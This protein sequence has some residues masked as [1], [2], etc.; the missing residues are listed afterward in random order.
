MLKPSGVI[1]CN[2]VCAPCIS[3]PRCARHTAWCGSHYATRD[4]PR[5]TSGHPSSGLRR[6]TAPR[7][8]HA[9]RVSRATRYALRP[10]SPAGVPRHSGHTGHPC[11]GCRPW[12]G[13]GT[14]P[15]GPATPPKRADARDNTAE[16]LVGSRGPRQASHAPSRLVVAPRAELP[17]AVAMRLVARGIR[18]Q[19]GPQEDVTAATPRQRAAKG[20]RPYGETPRVGGRDEGLQGPGGGDELHGRFLRTSGWSHGGLPRFCAGIYGVRATT[21]MRAVTAQVLPCSRD[22]RGGARTARPAW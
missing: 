3:S 17:C 21:R 16:V 4:A 1:G 10:L 13:R 22:N 9:S 11:S 6:S 14:P 15:S 2:F 5:F 7:L 19:L 20:V 12:S 18:T 8:G